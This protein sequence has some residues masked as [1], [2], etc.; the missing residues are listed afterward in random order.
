MRVPTLLLVQ[1]ST[2]SSRFDLELLLVVV[3]AAEGGRGSHRKST[4]ASLLLSL[5][6]KVFR[7]PIRVALRTLQTVSDQAI[8][9]SKLLTLELIDQ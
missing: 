6:C 2:A 1:T 9:S 8:V 5:V 7:P 3:V 4:C